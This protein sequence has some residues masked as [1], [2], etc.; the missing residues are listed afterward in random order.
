[1]IKSFVGKKSIRCLWKNFLI[2]GYYSVRNRIYFTKKNFP[3]SFL[4]Y[5]IIQLPYRVLRIIFG[6]LIYDDH[7]LNRIKLILKAIWD[8]LI[9][10][11]G[12]TIDPLEWRKD[13]NKR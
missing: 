2:S 10:K 7:K 4:K 8:G 1:M 13:L 11:M 5:C 3:K 6:I 9:G 12:K